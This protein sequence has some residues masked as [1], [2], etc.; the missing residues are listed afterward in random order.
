MRDGKQ[1]PE[2]SSDSGRFPVDR[3]TLPPGL[4]R[5]WKYSTKPYV[6]TYQTRRD[7]TIAVNK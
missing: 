7:F 2:A 6:P 5:T 4:P 1:E 3:A